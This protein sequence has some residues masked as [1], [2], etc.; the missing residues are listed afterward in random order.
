MKQITRMA[1]LALFLPLLV[2]A[3]TNLNKS[4]SGIKKIKMSTASGD[5]KISKN[6]GSA[7]TVNLKHTYEAGRYTPLIEQQGELLTIKEEFQSGNNN[8]QSTWTLTVPDEVEI[9][10]TSGSG[11]I[12]VADLKSDL[13][14][15]TGSG[16]LDFRNIK[17][18][19]KGTTGSGDVAFDHFDGTLSANTGSGNM[20]LANSKG[21]VS[22]SCGSGDLSL[23][24]SQVAIKANTGSGNI[25]GR[26]ITFNGKS[27]FNTGSGD[28][29]II[30]S[31]TPKYD[32]AIGSG[33]GNA[34]LDFNGNEIKG[35]IVMRAGKHQGEIIAPFDF[36]ETEEIN[37]G[38]NST[39]IQKSVVK[40]NGSNRINISTGSGDA[41]IKK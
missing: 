37:Q 14:I 8:G 9:A 38:G 4:F 7:V 10:L 5:C 41:V 2:S 3:Q 24:D 31:A 19:L 35:D 39:M 17:G 36:D 20:K 22:L 29:E 23:T 33:S 27:S 26:N 11:D 18:K 15:T 13:T 6:S 1:V 12:D 28:A 32:I 40:A 21:E 30:L 16:N 25:E 34:V